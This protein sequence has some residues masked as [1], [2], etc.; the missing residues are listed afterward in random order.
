[1]QTH[2]AHSCEMSI[3][4]PLLTFSRSMLTEWDN[5]KSPE[6]VRCWS[7]TGTQLVEIVATQLTVWLLMPISGF[8]QAI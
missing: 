2:Q 1:M 3:A 5:R 4:S 7:S 8:G 6:N